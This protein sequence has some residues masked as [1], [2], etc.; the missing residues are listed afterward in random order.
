MLIIGGYGIPA[1][2][3]LYICIKIF[4][5]NNSTFFLFVLFYFIYLQNLSAT[6]NH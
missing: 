3:F 5:A 1:V 4:Y 6:T 2:A